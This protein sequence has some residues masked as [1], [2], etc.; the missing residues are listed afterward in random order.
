M[1]KSTIAAAAAAIAMSGAAGAHEFA[2]EK[3][4]DGTVVRVVDHYPATLNFKIV[5]TNTHPSDKSTVLAVRDDVLAALGVTLTPVPF[6]LD[7]GQSVEFSASVTVRDQ[8]DCR[9]ISGA[10]AC[11]ASFAEAFQVIFDGGV[12][13]CGARVVCMKDE[14][15]SRGGEEN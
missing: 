2:C 7:V 8:A 3:T 9:K 10:Q 1:N 4:V 15:A 13:Q 14:R 5:L 6:T 12:A 11:T